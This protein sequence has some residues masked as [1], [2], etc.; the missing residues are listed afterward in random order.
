LVES[1]AK[2]IG[3]GLQAGDPCIVVATPAHITALEAALRKKNIDV[4][5]ATDGGSYR[6]LDAQACLSDISVDGLPDKTRFDRFMDTLLAET[7]REGKVTRVFG[8]MVALLWA[9]ENQAAAILLEGLWN[10]LVGARPITLFCAY[11][12]HYFANLGQENLLQQIGQLH[13]SLVMPRR[14]NALRTRLDKDTYKAAF[15]KSPLPGS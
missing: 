7:A 3:A 13:S 1:L 9:N 4:S 8:E 5:G 6:L 11:P 2:F 14:A 10:D 12:M 15:R